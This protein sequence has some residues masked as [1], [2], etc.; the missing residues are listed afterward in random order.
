MSGLASLEPVYAFSPV[1]VFQSG[2]A[3]ITLASNCA[4]PQASFNLGQTVCAEV[5]GAPQSI[6]GFRQRRVQWI[7]PDGKVALQTDITSDPYSD[8]FTLPTT[9]PLAQVGMWT[10]R[11]IN[12]RSQGVVSATFE[13]LDPAN[14]STD[15]SLT[16]NGPSQVAPGSNIAYIV[17]VNNNG[18]DAA[19]NVLVLNDVPFGAGF[20][21]ATQTQGAAF[22]C[23]TPAVG[24]SGT[25]TC[26]RSSLAAN[27]DA[28]FIFTFSV[29]AATP[30]GTSIANISRVTTATNE[31]NKRNNLALDISS[32]D[33]LPVCNISC[34]TDIVVTAPADSC[35]VN[36]SYPDPTTSGGTCG[37][38]TRSHASGSFF[39]IGTTTVIL[40]GDSG[41]PCTFNITVQGTL[42]PPT[43]SCPA[44]ITAPET[45]PGSGF[46]AINVGT[47]TTTSDCAGTTVEGIRSDGLRLDSPYPVGTTNIT[48]T[49]TDLAGNTVSCQQTVT[50]T[51]SGSACQLSCPSDVNVNTDANSCGAI[52]NYPAPTGGDECGAITVSKASGTFFPVGTTT[53]NVTSASGQSCS[54]NVTVVDAQDPVIT[55]PANI[56]TSVAPNQ[57]TANVNVVAPT[58]TDNCAVSVGGDRSDG[59]E[60]IAPYP[61]GTTVITWAATDASGNATTCQQT[62]T[63]TD[64]PTISAPSDITVNADNNSCAAT[65][66]ALG[67]ATAVSNCSG[68]N[69]TNNAPSSFPVGMTTVIWTVTDGGGQTATDTQTVTVVDN[70]NPTISAPPSL[71]VGTGANAVSCSAFVGDATLGNANASDNCAV[72]VARSG[73]P[74]GNVFPLGTTTI[75]YTATD[76][77]GHTATATQT[78]TVVDNTAPV[79]SC[80]S[81][82]VVTL[83]LNTP[84]TSMAVNYPAATVSDNCGT[85]T[86]AY[87]KPSGTV[88]NVGTTPVVVNATDAAGN[89]SSCT[90]TVTVLYNFTGFFSPISNLPTLNIVNAGRAIPVKWSLSG[91]KGMNIFAAGYPASGV[92]TCNSNDPVVEVTDTNTAG[93]S[94]LT[95]DA[96]SDQY[97]YNWKTEKAWEGT[98]RQLVIRLNDGSEHRANFKF[99]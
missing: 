32:I 46:A 27:T 24:E 74:A 57:C 6:F 16:M 77:S 69:V 44:N 66:V 68:F 83:P 96:G 62:V 84:A 67:N 35:G 25:I 53:V 85:P 20:V 70:Q 29:D 45:T 65:N 98:C 89:A 17:T 11:T 95:Y 2:E 31:S 88:F 28:A 34:P 54:F 38:I 9:G 79:L 21:S 60:L 56:T 19:Q 15:L 33:P 36:V 50:I 55:C 37:T 7:T 52:V 82:I 91:N 41:D 64:T 30:A 72:T 51:G 76:A 80:P 3:I 86:L 12:N 73:V 5:V 13:V 59:E 14:A 43:I 40:S 97:H 49:A 10:V 99:K 22:N 81:N 4:T 23:V 75:T 63:V 87:S 26:T 61:V 1:A 42:D 58:A 39:P 94:T 8:S 93:S 78:V 18:P 90:F 71:T 48:W 92:I 47:A